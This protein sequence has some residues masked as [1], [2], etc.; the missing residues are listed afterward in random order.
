M[1]FK[2]KIG[3]YGEE[4]AEAYLKL[5]DYKILERNFRCSRGEI[6]LI[7]LDKDTIVFVEIKSRTNK[8]YGVPSES[9]NKKKLEHIYKTAGYF[10]YIRNIENRDTR[11]DVIEIYSEPEKCYINHLKQVV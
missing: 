4:L 1:Y 8:E 6:D 5:I 9:V 3:K 7:A 11:I 10:L 2:Q